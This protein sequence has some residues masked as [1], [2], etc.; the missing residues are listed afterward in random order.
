MELETP[1]FVKST[2]EGARDFLVPSRIHKGKF[3]ALPQSPQIYK[4]LTMIAGFDKYFQIARCYRDEDSRGDRQPEFTQLDLE[5]SFIKKENIFKLMEGLIS[6]VFKQALNIKLPKKFK[7]ISY[8]DA[9]NTYG[10]DKP[11]IRYELTIQDM[12][13]HLKNLHSMY[14]K[15]HSKIRIQ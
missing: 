7:R 10:S 4:Q 2:P 3:Y 9:M 8:K 1:T 6:S 5:M 13:H 15:K 14:L 11:D 12:G